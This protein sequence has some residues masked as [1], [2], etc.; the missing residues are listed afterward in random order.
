LYTTVLIYTDCALVH[1]ITF[2]I[3][4][5]VML[6]ELAFFFS[7]ISSYTTMIEYIQQ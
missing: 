7:F 4:Y 5:P 6:F 2:A 1:P 3:S